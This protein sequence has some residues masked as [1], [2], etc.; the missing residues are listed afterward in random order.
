MPNIVIEAAHLD[1]S[2]KN[3]LIRSFTKTASELTSI[4]ESFFTVL[5]KEYPVD[6]WGIGGKPLD[7]ILKTR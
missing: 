1:K 2:Q 7:E 6:N 5:V 3:A 4:P